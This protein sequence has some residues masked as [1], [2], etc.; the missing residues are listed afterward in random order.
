MI[1]DIL[2]TSHFW[3]DVA[4][5]VFFAWTLHIDSKNTLTHNFTSEKPYDSQYCNSEGKV[6]IHYDIYSDSVKYK[7]DTGSFF[8]EVAFLYEVHSIPETRIIYDFKTGEVKYSVY[9]TILAA[10][11]DSIEDFHLQAEKN[12]KMFLNRMNH[13]FKLKHEYEMKKER[14]GI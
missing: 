14:L 10:N 11:F 3:F 13:A 12:A 1:K 7:C 2:K 8:K 4:V 5:F 9:S 6:T